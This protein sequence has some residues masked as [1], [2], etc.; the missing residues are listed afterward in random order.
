MK[1][2]FHLFNQWKS[3]DLAVKNM[4][5]TDE[6][7]KRQITDSI[8]KNLTDSDLEST[9]NFFSYKY[10]YNY[11]VALIFRLSKRI[12][13]KHSMSESYTTILSI[14]IFEE[15]GDTRF[16]AFFKPISHFYACL[17]FLCIIPTE[18]Q[19]SG[20]FPVF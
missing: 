12:L 7:M 13:H 3:T 5:F 17:S 9:S 4:L 14:K 16:L 15:L 8:S 11:H 19:F 1:L 18:Y 2:I 10:V 20:F 6:S